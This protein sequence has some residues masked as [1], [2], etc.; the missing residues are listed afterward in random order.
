M[1]LLRLPLPVFQ[2]FQHELMQLFSGEGQK[3]DH[4]RDAAEEFVSLEM[5]LQNG[6]HHVVLERARDGDSLFHFL[7]NVVVGVTAGGFFDLLLEEGWKGIVFFPWL[8]ERIK[9]K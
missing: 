2:L 6:L 7:L 8:N 4:F 9:E 1:V 3:V 5:P